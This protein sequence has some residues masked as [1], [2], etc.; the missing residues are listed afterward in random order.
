MMCGVLKGRN[1]RTLVFVGNNREFKKW[2][3][4]MREYGKVS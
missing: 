3:H 2:L 4:L 1:Y